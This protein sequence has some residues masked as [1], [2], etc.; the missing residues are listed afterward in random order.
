MAR[1]LS[2]TDAD[3]GRFMRMVD[4]LPSGC[5]FWQG[6]RS[7][8]KGNRK[9]YGTFHVSGHGSVRAHRFADRA[10]GGMPE[11]EPGWHR[12]HVCCFSL[13]VNPA[14]LEHVTHEENQARKLRRK[15]GAA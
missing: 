12:D 7:R 14:H 10:L 5:W 3:V 11:L 1:Q 6:A 15:R 8:G 13:C 9:W 2:W 4:V